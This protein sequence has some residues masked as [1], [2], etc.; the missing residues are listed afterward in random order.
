MTS[1]SN[2]EGSGNRPITAPKGGTGGVSTAANNLDT[3]RGASTKNVMG[4]GGN[5][6]EHVRFSDINR[7]ERRPSKEPFSGFEKVLSRAKPPKPFIRRRYLIP[8]SRTMLIRYRES[9]SPIPT[10]GEPAGLQTFYRPGS[11]VASKIK[12]TRVP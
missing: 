11:S 2:Q 9:N 4:K 3:E 1:E 7:S 6:V 12:S 8:I 10:K 5:A